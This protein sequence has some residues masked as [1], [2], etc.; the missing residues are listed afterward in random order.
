MTWQLLEPSGP[1]VLICQ[2]TLISACKGSS[3]GSRR[4]EVRAKHQ[5]NTEQRKRLRAQCTAITSTGTRGTKG[6]AGFRSGVHLLTDVAQIR[7]KHC[8]CGH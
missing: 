4:L 7:A 8:V 6:K 3:K 1:H 2:V 5:G